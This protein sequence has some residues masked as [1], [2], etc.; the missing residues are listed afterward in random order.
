MRILL[1]LFLVIIG[2]R[3]II[4]GMEPMIEDHNPPLPP[5]PPVTEIPPETNHE[6]PASVVAENPAKETEN[7]YPSNPNTE[8]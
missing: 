2:T 8:S 1:G 4:A 5:I 6:I 7:V 3:E